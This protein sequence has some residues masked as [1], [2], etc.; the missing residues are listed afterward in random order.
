MSKRRFSTLSLALFVAVLLF[1]CQE[2]D[3]PFECTDAIGCVEIAPGEP[4]RL[5]MIQALSGGMAHVGVVQARGMELAIARRGDQLFGHP[6]A[7]QSEDAQCSPEGGATAA[8]K[9]AADP[10]TVA[11]LGPTCSGA[12]ATAAKIM[13]GAGLVMVSGGAT[14]PSLTALDGEQGDDWQPGFLRTRPNSAEQGRAAAVFVF[15]ELEVTRV[16]TI[17]DGDPYT[18]GIADVFQRTF[19][20]LGG[21]IA[22]D[23]VINRG[24]TDMHPVLTAVAS[25]GAELVF[26]PLVLPE[27]TFVARQAKE[28][29]GL[30]NIL[31]MGSRGLRSD[32]FIESVGTD[33]VGMYFVGLISPEGPASDELASEY[34]SRYGDL[35]ALPSYTYAYDAANMLLNAIEAVAVQEEDGTLHIG[36][37]ALRD[38]LY[39]T[40]DLA[41]VSGA[42]TCDQFGDC[43][44]GEFNVVR[45]DDP[46]AGIKGLEAN[47]VYAYTPGP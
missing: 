22:L 42:L 6:I 31:L 16:A 36:R 34:E 47:I 24:D 12:A 20:E 15:Q 1:A 44:T 38:E 2:V 37:Q 10:Q 46:F 40:A 21:E 5:G 8:L 23:G 39:A 33:G 35:P 3:P 30:G 41:G 18:R 14:A 9:V 19:A 7:V 11:I 4:I 29:A 45:L 13:S 25:S 32:A 28:V 26:F 27:G 17:H 43:G